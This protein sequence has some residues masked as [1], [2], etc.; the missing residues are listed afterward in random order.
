MAK[1]KC[2]YCNG[3]VFELCTVEILDSRLPHC[4]IQ[5][6]KPGC[7]MPVGVVESRNIGAL[8]DEMTERDAGFRQAV[9]FRLGGIESRL[10]TIA[11]AASLQK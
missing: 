10:T 9:F 11:A 6:A 3:L 5:C 8:L 4:F 1:S 7:G 2:F